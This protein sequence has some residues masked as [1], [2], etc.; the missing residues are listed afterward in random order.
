MKKTI[1]TACSLLL[2]LSFASCNGLFPAEEHPTPHH[3]T[4]PV[5]EPTPGYNTSVTITPTTPGQPGLW[6]AWNFNGNMTSST[7]PDHSVFLGSN[8]TA[9]KIGGATAQQGTGYTLLITNLTGSNPSAMLMPEGG[10]TPQSVTVQSIEPSTE[11][12]AASI[13]DT[14][15]PSANLVLCVTHVGGGVRILLEDA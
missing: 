5:I 11:T 10:G 14:N 15:P 4:T 6:V 7:P 3:P 12:F 1:R 8:E 2:G 9:F 13:R